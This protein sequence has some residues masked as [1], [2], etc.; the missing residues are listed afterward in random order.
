MKQTPTHK[1]YTGLDDA[2]AYF[3]KRLF[4][5]RLPHCLITVRR[6]QGEYGYF[7]AERFSS[8]DG[9][10]I[11]DEIALNAKHFKQRSQREILST[12]VHEMVHQEQKHFGK[13]S[14]NGYHNKEWSHW[15]ERIGLMPSATGAPGGKRTGQRMTHYIIRGGP[16]DRAF[17]GRKFRDLY[18]DRIDE[19]DDARAKRKSVYTCPNCDAKTYAN[20]PDMFLIHGDCNERMIVSYDTNK[21]ATT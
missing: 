20:R 2:F 16:F 11:T 19:R 14:R 3:N 21:I 10:E 12:L 8:R 9:R 4:A 18:F 15:M 5:D 17:R 1:T 7:S 13:P 6:H